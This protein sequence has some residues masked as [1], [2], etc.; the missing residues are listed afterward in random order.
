MLSCTRHSLYEDV[1][2]QLLETGF[3]LFICFMVVIVLLLFFY[4]PFITCLLV[5]ASTVPHPIPLPT[6][7]QNEVLN[8]T[9]HQANRLPGA[10]NLPRFRASSL[11]GVTPG[12]PLLYVYWGPWA[13]SCILAGWRRTI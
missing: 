6:F 2:G 1:T 11:T 7:L 12:S 9:P 5:H 4:S 13:S 10:S 8:L 3:L